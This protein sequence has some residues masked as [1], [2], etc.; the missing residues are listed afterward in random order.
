MVDAVESGYGVRMLAVITLS[1]VILLSL[2]ISRIG[3]VALEVTGLGRDAARFQARSALS[4]AGFTTS[5][6]EAVVEHPGRRRVVALLILV[7]SGGL[8]TAVATS[9]LTFSGADGAEEVSSRIAIVGLGALATFLLARSPWFDRALRRVLRPLLARVHDLRVADYAALLHI[10][11]EWQVT[12]LV[13]DDDDHWLLDR[14]LAEHD[15]PEEGILV[16]GIERADGTFLGAPRSTTRV[17]RDD[18]LILYGRGD[19]LT[20]LSRRHHDDVRDRSAAIADH[21]RELLQ[22]DRLDENVGDEMQRN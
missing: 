12:E 13:V 21:H 3:A 19:R 4:G 18:R 20:S 11:G 5:E 2:V 1:I 9:L 10:T 7:G 8:V 16:L 22:Q 17:L 15:L 14:T 6:S